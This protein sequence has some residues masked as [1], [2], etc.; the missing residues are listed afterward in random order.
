[1]AEPPGWISPSEEGGG[2]GGIAKRRAC[3]LHIL[4]CTRSCIADGHHSLITAVAY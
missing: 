1:M 2:A 4:R 3:Q